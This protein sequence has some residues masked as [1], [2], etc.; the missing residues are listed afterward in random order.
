MD[1]RDYYKEHYFLEATRKNDLTN[2]LSLPLAIL[3]LLIGGLAVVARKIHV[4][5]DPLAILQLTLM[6][7]AVVF[8][9]LTVY[10]FIR[11]YYNY[12]YGYVPT[13]LEIKTYQEKLIAYYISLGVAP[14]AANQKSKVDVLAHID[15][16]YAKHADLNAKNNN[17]KS[18]F[19]HNANSSLIVAVILTLAVAATYLVAS[20]R[21]ASQPEKINIVNLKDIK[22]APPT[23]NTPQSPPTAPQTTTPAPVPHGKPTPPPGQ[24]LKEHVDPKHK[25]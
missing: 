2:A 23:S 8:I 15:A 12:E 22:M 14:D 11:S 13:P 24:L 10:F 19:I 17:R 9:L 6:A 3:S 4:P 7:L 1:I 20:I 5:L 25:K 16:E 18:S 21:T